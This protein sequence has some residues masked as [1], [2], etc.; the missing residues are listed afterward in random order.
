MKVYINSSLVP[1]GNIL[2]GSESVNKK[3]SFLGRISSNT[4][5]ITIIN[6]TGTT[7]SNY[8]NKTIQLKDDSDNVLFT[9]VT[10]LA[11]ELIDNA[12]YQLPFRD[13]WYQI[14]NV[15]CDNKTYK[16][17][18]FKSTVED[19]ISMSGETNYN[20]EDPSLTITWFS[21]TVD[22]KIQTV[23]EKLAQSVGGEC[24]YD[25]EGVL[26][27]T[28]GFASPFSTTTSRTLTASNSV[29]PT[30]EDIIDTY[31][32]SEVKWK[33]KT[34]NDDTV[35]ILDGASPDRPIVIPSSGLG[36]SDD[37]YVQTKAK[38]HELSAYSTV[39]FA[40][41]GGS[42]ALD[43][44]VYDSNFQTGSQ[45]YTDSKVKIKIT[46]S[47]GVDKFVQ[48]LKFKGKEIEEQNVT[49]TYDT[50][51]N[52]LTLTSDVVSDATWAGKLS[53]WRLEQSTDQVN[54]T[55]SIADFYLN[56][57]LGDKFLYDSVRYKITGINFTR[58]SMNI[59]AVKDRTSAFS[60]NSGNVSY[61]YDSDFVAGEDYDPD[62]I[63]GD[64]LEPNSYGFIDASCNAYVENRKRKAHLEWQ[65]VST[66]SQ[67]IKN[68]RIIYW[69]RV[70]DTDED[71][72]N[73]RALTYGGIYI[74][75]ENTSEITVDG[76]IFET[77]IEIEN[78]NEWRFA[79]FV[80]DYD[81]YKRLYFTGGANDGI[82]DIDFDG[83]DIPT[84]IVNQPGFVVLTTFDNVIFCTM[85]PNALD[86]GKEWILQVQAVETTS[87]WG[88]DYIEFSGEQG[89]QWEV[90]E[91]YS[92]RVP[93]E[94]SKAERMFKV[95]ARFK[96]ENGE[97]GPWSV[98][99]YGPVPIT[100]GSAPAT[101]TTLTFAQITEPNYAGTDY[102]RFIKLTCNDVP[103]TE[104]YKWYITYGTTL[105]S[106][107]YFEVESN[108]N[109]IYIAVDSFSSLYN[110]AHVI[111]SNSYGDSG[112]K[113]ISTGL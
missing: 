55:V 37:Y 111:A 81:G 58:S 13:K 95:R 27:F 96:D 15:T 53:Q 107:I 45:P 57:D 113:Y 46:N 36:V 74:P 64:G 84:D 103:N 12:R 105:S 30:I 19:I 85:T 94:G 40:G 106:E 104:K 51:S 59:T 63:S 98:V 26:Q 28:A 97:V 20:V 56:L 1:A 78:T 79:L 42:L 92:I 108:E 21:V 31:D 82:I 14:R 60:Y 25:S 17:A 33:E 9:G 22:D 44:T 112:R 99:D 10:L 102:F 38:I 29:K 66:P 35:V 70:I 61:R 76:S 65:A 2:A 34:F 109:E 87:E 110:Y 86:V 39:N 23:L 4:G 6:K 68:F 50:G 8:E 47:S 89:Y 80:E 62:S 16:N 11:K 43:Q 32:Y 49:A 71:L 69:D 67:D 48:S 3:M 75:N 83:Y 24:Y 5:S 18:D 101:P 91:T 73:A 72:A 54:F 77:E 88:N 100:Y 7:I 93:V 52:L 41:G 90:G